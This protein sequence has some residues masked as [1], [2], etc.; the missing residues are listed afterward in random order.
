MK[1]ILITGH[2][3]FIG[4]HVLRHFVYTYP[5]YD[6]HGLDSLTY[7]ADI[8]NVKDV[9][10]KYTMHIQDIRNRDEVMALFEREKF[11]DVIHLAAES[12]VDNSIENPLIFA[13][14]NILGTLNLLDAFRKYSTGRFHHV[15]TDEVYGYL[16]KGDPEFTET[17]PYDPSSPYSASKASSDHFVR[18][19]HRTYGIDVTIT[20]CS[21]NYGPNQNYEKFIPT[22]IRSIMNN[23]QIPIYGKGENIRDWLYVGEHATAI[24][25]VFHTGVPGETYNVGGDKEL[26]NLE[27]VHIICD[28]MYERGYCQS[29]PRKLINFVTDRLGHDF[30]YAI[31]SSKISQKLKWAPYPELFKQN[32]LETI[33]WFAEIYNKT[34]E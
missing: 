30:R 2:A 31:N 19:Y 15:S 14:T 6:I 24:D 10:S 27:L 7:A 18:A 8:N 29:D 11:T 23:Q 25:T 1:K 13:E 21:N 9:Q 4:S 17:T 3:G 20:N 26:T 5:E 12:H 33:D 34:K 16:H 32:L 22:I 28:M